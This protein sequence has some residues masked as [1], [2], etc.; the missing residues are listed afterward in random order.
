MA[1]LQSPVQIQM[2]KNNW[3]CRLNNEKYRLDKHES[4]VAGSDAAVVL[5][6]YSNITL[7]VHKSIYKYIISDRKGWIN[8]ISFGVGHHNDSF[9]II[10][11]FLSKKTKI[12][13]S[14][15][16]VE[17]LTVGLYCDIE[18]MLMSCF[19]KWKKNWRSKN[20]QNLIMKSYLHW[21]SLYLWIV[22]V[23]KTETT[24]CSCS[25]I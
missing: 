22:C 7:S 17:T 24:S 10:V 16:P 6:P 14:Q 9:L 2:P 1:D 5:I 20:R 11:F 19:R 8:L 4:H 25:Q 21:E 23:L 3:N 18:R 15:S 12:S 13:G